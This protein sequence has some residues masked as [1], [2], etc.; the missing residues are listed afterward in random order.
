[1]NDPPA[2]PK[3]RG[4]A[5]LLFGGVLALV[6]AAA[7][8][9]IVPGVAKAA[10]QICSNQTGTNGGMYYQMWSNGQGSACITLNSS[11]S[12]STRGAA[13]ATSSPALAGTLAATRR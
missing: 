5:R 12:Y 3:R 10:T 4:L 8:A 13:S 11:N 1:M 9:A 7:T 2:H 6:L